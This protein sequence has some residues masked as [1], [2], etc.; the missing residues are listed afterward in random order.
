[1]VNTLQIISSDMTTMHTAA[2]VTA[3]ADE[4]KEDLSMQSLAY[5]IN[6][7][8]NTGCHKAYWNW[9]LTDVMKTALETNGYTYEKYGEGS[10]KY[11]Y[12]IKWQ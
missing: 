1:M 7:A 4:A 3:V 9:A 5:T 8:A 12:V 10:D 11:G 6:Y 2:E